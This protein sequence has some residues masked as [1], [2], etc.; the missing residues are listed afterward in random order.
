MS[1]EQQ[2]SERHKF[3]DNLKKAV[4][5]LQAMTAR[6]I[7]IA[8]AR[9]ADMRASENDDSKKDEISLKRH[10][11]LK[12]LKLIESGNLV[13][14]KKLRQKL[15]KEVDMQRRQ[16]E[17]AIKHRKQEHYQ[18]VCNEWAKNVNV[19]RSFFYIGAPKFD[20]VIKDLSLPTPSILSWG[21]DESQALTWKYCS[22]NW[23]HRCSLE[24]INDLRL[25]K[26]V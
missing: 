12:F 8:I 23:P 9:L 4:S 14:L 7:E 10:V 16:T 19:L 18:K 17:F 5:I 24:S 26:Y 15:I 3:E 1:Y 11:A 13:I 22:I 20:T 6:E 21:W 25:E 2:V